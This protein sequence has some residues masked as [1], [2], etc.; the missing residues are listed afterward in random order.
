MCGKRRKTSQDPPEQIP[1][2]PPQ[3]ASLHTNALRAA[4]LQAAPQQSRQTQLP[5]E[6]VQ[7]IL[8]FGTGVPRC[9]F[10]KGKAYLFLLRNVKHKDPASFYS[11]LYEQRHESS[12]GSVSAIANDQLVVCKE[13]CSVWNSYTKR[14]ISKSM[15]S[16]FDVITSFYLVMKA[17]Y[18]SIK[19]L[20][21]SN[22]PSIPFVMT[23]SVLERRMPSSVVN[24]PRIRCS[25]STINY[26]SGHGMQYTFNPVPGSDKFKIQQNYRPGMASDRSLAQSIA[27][28]N[29][30]TFKVE[31]KAEDLD[32]EDD[33]GLY[34]AAAEYYRTAIG[35]IEFSFAALSGSNDKLLSSFRQ[36]ARGYS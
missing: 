2:R 13:K 30:Y 14:C 36:V 28:L 22:A 9:G 11:N 17:L 23:L 31:F 16:H 4:S 3:T 29:E 27:S 12:F 19:K 10:L 8:K 18:D 15:N 21:P 20:F 25:S 7:K 24:P 26:S 35:F 5:E 34:D 33:D 6:V 32:I 1:I